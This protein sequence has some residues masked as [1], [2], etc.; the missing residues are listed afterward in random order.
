MFDFLESASNVSVQLA[1]RIRCRVSDCIATPMRFV[2]S[3]FHDS[4]SGVRFLPFDPKHVL[5][6]R[7][8]TPSVVDGSDNH[9]PN[10]Q[11]R[12]HR[13]KWVL[14]VAAE[15]LI[16]LVHGQLEKSINVIEVIRDY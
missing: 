9:P 8:Q 1:T 7:L 15:E 11:V 4:G 16:N 12:I 14:L 3:G 13:V 2:L 6:A 5:T 10:V